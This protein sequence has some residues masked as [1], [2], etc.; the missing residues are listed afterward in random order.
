MP[1]SR[2]VYCTCRDGRHGH[3]AAMQTELGSLAQWQVLPKHLP[4]KNP[5]LHTLSTTL[6]P[7]KGGGVCVC[8]SNPVLWLLAP[9]AHLCL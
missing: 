1:P 6:S 2:T 4:Q 8:V 9:V 3:A 5:N 7:C